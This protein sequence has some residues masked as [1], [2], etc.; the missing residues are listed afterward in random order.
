MDLLKSCHIVLYL[1][2]YDIYPVFFF[3]SKK[4]EFIKV[5]PTISF[6]RD[7]GG[8]IINVLKFRDSHFVERVI[9]HLNWYFCVVCFK[10][11]FF[12]KFLNIEPIL[13]R[14]MA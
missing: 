6:F 4:M 9:L 1:K 10:I 14:K 11:L 8:K 13:V 5:F 7:F 3:I 2:V 12:C